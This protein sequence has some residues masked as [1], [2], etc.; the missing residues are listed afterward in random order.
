MQLRPYRYAHYQKDEIERIIREMLQSGV[1]RDSSSPF[2]SSAIL[3]G[4]K[5]G[6]W[7]LCIYYRQL[8]EVTIKDKYP[9]PVIDDLLDELSGAK[10]FSK[11]DLRSGYHQIRMA[12]GD[13]YKTAFRTHC[14]HYD[15]LVMPFGLTNAP[16]TFQSLMNRLFEPSLR[17]FVL[18]FF[19]DIL[20]YSRD[21]Q[22]HT[23]HLQLVFEIGKENQ[24]FAKRTK[25]SFGVYK[26][27]YLG[28]IISG[29]GVAT[30][31]DKIK[32]MVQWPKPW[33]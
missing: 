18:V 13:V 28:H 9:I 27:E 24:L 30:D 25:C 23:G 1:I 19:D 22:E 21:E 2:A 14:G 12:E 17:K 26:I 4:K 33:N 5:D 8:N 29:D 15:F 31:P 3:A 11:L 32:A 7:I 6:T 20:V 10:V 16:A